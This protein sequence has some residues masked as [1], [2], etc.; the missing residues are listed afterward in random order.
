MDLESGGNLQSRAAMEL[1]QSLQ[2]IQEIIFILVWL[3]LNHDFYCA[4]PTSAVQFFLIP[5]KIYL[6]TLNIEVETTGTITDSLLFTNID[7]MNNR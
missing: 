7:F 5:I 3:L 1:M 4:Q 6:I 2:L